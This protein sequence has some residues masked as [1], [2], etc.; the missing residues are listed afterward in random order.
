[1]R[2]HVLSGISTQL[3]WG[4]DEVDRLFTTSFGSQVFGLF[5]AWYN[6]RALDPHGPISANLFCGIKRIAALEVFSCEEPQ[7]SFPKSPA[8]SRRPAPR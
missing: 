3:F 7:L 5:L 8:N 4:M 1:M 6:K 2:R